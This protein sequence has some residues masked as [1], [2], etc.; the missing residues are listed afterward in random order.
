MTGRGIVNLIPGVCWVVGASDFCNGAVVYGVWFPPNDRGLIWELGGSGKTGGTIGLRSTGLSYLSTC[1]QAAPAAQE[2]M[3]HE[4]SSMYLKRCMYPSSAAAKP[5]ATIQ[6]F[7]G[8]AQR[9]S[10]FGTSFL[11][12]SIVPAGVS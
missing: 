12:V 1:A 10:R 3:M 8:L 6:V 9:Q 4:V 11:T 2:T 7:G 5:L